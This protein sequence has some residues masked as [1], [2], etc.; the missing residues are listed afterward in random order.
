MEE[1]PPNS[2]KA[3]QGAAK[4]VERVTSGSAVRRKRG[5]G[6]SFKHTFIGGDANTAVQYMV[7]NV[8]VPAARDMMVEAFQAGVEKLVY[9][10]ARPKRGRGGPT[11]GPLGYVAY[12]RQG[13][14]QRPDDRPPMPRMLPRRSRA[15]HDF[16]DIEIP[17]RAEAEEV[18]ERM[19][20]LISKYESVTVADL[21]E[22]T[23]L[24][25]SH[26]DHKWGWVS[27]QGA[28]VGRV[29][30]GGYLLDLPEPVHFE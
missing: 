18:L 19:Y 25:S 4:R 21:Y 30:G 3:E 27:L 12:N 14:V 23:G 8:L 15:R 7:F 2:H 6:S 20:D 28:S 17:T 16:D 13:P 5:L 29:R 11:A 22:L 9:G 26:V 1:F 10:D 24:Q